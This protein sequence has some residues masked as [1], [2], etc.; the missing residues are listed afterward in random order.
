[1]QP[2]CCPPDVGGQRSPQ[3]EGAH[4]CS[5][6]EE[7][8]ER[9]RPHDLKPPVLPAEAGAEELDVPQSAS[10]RRLLSCHIPEELECKRSPQ[11]VLLVAA[12]GVEVDVEVASPD[13]CMA[14]GKCVRELKHKGRLPTS[15]LP[16]DG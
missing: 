3:G 5:D 4:H 15:P 10:P 7:D 12:P 6:K 2:C 1:M 16:L 11:R 13:G 8:P 9:N 14:P